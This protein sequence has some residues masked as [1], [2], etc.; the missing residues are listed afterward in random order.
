MKTM[1]VNI[2]FTG[3]DT[4]DKLRAYAEEKVAAFEK[5]LSDEDYAEAVCD[6]EFRSSTHHQK[7]DVC[8]AEVNLDAKGTLYRSSKEEPSFNKAIDK[9][10]DDILSQLRREKEQRETALR[11][12]GLQIK[13][14]LL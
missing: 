7:G 12:G 8:Y 5:L 2:K 14:E 3:I 1:Q 11:R 6:V 13:E 10:K 9:V 4:S